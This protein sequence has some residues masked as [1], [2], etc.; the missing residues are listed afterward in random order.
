MCQVQSWALE[1]GAKV[2]RPCPQEAYSSGGEEREPDKCNAI[3]SEVANSS[4]CKDAVRCLAWMPSACLGVTADAV[5]HPPPQARCG[6][7]LL[8]A[9]VLLERLQAE[10]GLQLGSTTVGG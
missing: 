5:D 9:L 8:S 7:L 3:G 2:H 10:G 4:Q 1:S 6:P